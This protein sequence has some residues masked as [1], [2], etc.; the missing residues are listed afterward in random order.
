MP[1]L[2]RAKIVEALRK[3]DARLGARGERAEFF[4]LGGAVMC[5]V[6]R[7]RPATKDVDAWFTEPRAVRAA[8][9]EVA[10]EMGLPENWLNDAAKGFLPANAG[11]EGWEAFPHLTVSTVDD[12]TLLAMKCAAARTEEDAA[13]IR[14][15]TDR[16]GLRTS[17]EV[18]SV[19]TAYY[20]QELL[21]VRARL[22]LEEMLDERA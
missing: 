10:A 6:H 11:Y 1:L 17:A 21:P 9:G 14:F 2:D 22:L 18:L 8:A 15:L 3:L 20:P 13:D 19:V 12:R 4:L 7:A 5:V 16:L